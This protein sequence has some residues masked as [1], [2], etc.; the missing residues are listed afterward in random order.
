M[1]LLGTLSSFFN[2]LVIVAEGPGFDSQLDP[3]GFFFLSLQN[4]HQVVPAYVEPP[5]QH[6]CSY[7]VQLTQLSTRFNNLERLF[8]TECQALYA[9]RRSYGTEMLHK[10]MKL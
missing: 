4:L 9:Q 1:S 2:G 10:V 6:T 8:C 3:Y 5:D 7:T